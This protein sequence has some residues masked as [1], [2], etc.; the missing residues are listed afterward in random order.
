VIHLWDPFRKASAKLSNNTDKTNF[1]ASGHSAWRY[2]LPAMGREAV[3]QILEIGLKKM[4]AFSES[5]PR[6]LL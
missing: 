2:L 3:E 5:L 1:A 6:G 4:T